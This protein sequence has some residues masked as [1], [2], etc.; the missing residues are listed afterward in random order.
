MKHLV[1]L[2]RMMRVAVHWDLITNDKGINNHRKIRIGDL[3]QKF[4][5][6]EQIKSLIKECYKSKHPFL[7]YE[8]EFLILTEARCGQICLAK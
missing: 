7:G 1:L 4:L 5:V 6:L 8:V 2:K 3:Q